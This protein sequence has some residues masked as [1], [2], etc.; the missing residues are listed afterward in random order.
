[1]TGNNPLYDPDQNFQPKFPKMKRLAAM[2]IDHIFMSV[3]M[4]VLM[5][6]E[7]IYALIKSF[8]I[9]HDSR[10]PGQETLIF[11]F[12]AGFS[13]Y[14]NKDFFNGRSIAKRILNL[15]VISNNSRETATPLQCFIRNITI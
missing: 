11:L 2:L 9:S 5:L 13:V 1:M 3:F 12:I 6:P 8:E 7:F 14:L 10:F 15:Q 4:F